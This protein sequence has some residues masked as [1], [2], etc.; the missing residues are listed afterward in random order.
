MDKLTVKELLTLKGGADGGGEPGCLKELEE[1]AISHE[2]PDTGD[3]ER[4]WAMEEA[5]WENW[6]RRYNECLFSSL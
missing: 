1:E 2:M 6:E 4:D 5:F 3:E